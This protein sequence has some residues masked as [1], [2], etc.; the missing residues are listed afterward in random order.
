M[1]AT[2]KRLLIREAT[3]ASLVTTPKWTNNMSEEWKATPMS[4]AVHYKGESPHFDD[5][6]VVVSTDD[7]AGGAF[8]VLRSNEEKLEEGHIR[9]DM[10]QLELIVKEARKL[11]NATKD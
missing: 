3:R 6:S 2:T 5:S 4:V 9:V 11:I 1:T 7:E 8:I 10:A